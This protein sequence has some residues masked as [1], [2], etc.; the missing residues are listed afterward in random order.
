[1]TKERR[2]AIAMWE[3][4]RDNYDYAMNWC[5]RYNTDLEDAVIHI[6]KDFLFKWGMEDAW[7]FDCWL[8]HYVGWRGKTGRRYNYARCDRCPLQ[9]CGN[10]DSAYFVLT[11]AYDSEDDWIA[12]CNQIIEALGGNTND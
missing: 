7:A 2:I 10:D 1:M 4:V 12:A 9:S 11:N 5:D 8:C 6:K 3:H